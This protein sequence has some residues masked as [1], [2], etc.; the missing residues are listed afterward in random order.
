MINPLG[1][2]PTQGNHGFHWVVS[3]QF[4]YLYF[5]R[6]AMHRLLTGKVIFEDHKFPD[7]SRHFISTQ[8]AKVT[9]AIIGYHYYAEDKLLLA[10]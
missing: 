8:A 5:I 3:I 7:F 2:L 6:V 10:F 4:D 9:D 1:P